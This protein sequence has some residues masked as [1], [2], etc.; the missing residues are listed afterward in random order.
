M[1]NGKSSFIN[2]TVLLENIANYVSYINS[3]EHECIS[4]HQT[5]SIW[6]RKKICP[7]RAI[8]LCLQLKRKGEY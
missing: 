8:S 5:F 1:S 6:Y 2:N 3:P 4:E 7:C